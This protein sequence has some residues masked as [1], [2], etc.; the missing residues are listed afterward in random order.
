[1]N[2]ELMPEEKII[3]DA[4]RQYDCLKTEQ[5]IELIPYKSR[6]LVSRIIMGL[7]KRQL[8]I[9]D[10]SGNVRHDPRCDYDYKIEIAFWI[11]LKYIATGDV[12][13]NEHY[14][15]QYPSQIF[16]LK[17]GKQY[18]IFVLK[19]NE[20]H[21]LNVLVKTEQ[22]C[23]PD[24]PDEET[25]EFDDETRF[26]I[27]IPSDTMIPECNR[28]LGNLKHIFAVYDINTPPGQEPHVKFFK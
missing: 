1:M 3:I 17:G 2:N 6:E 8:L 4:L 14:R 21:L 24:T 10:A 27:A 26:I 12:K 13:Y 25:D 9:T 19:P 5:L 16:F 7:H 22:N 15:A 23:M 28:R 11:L 18:E 20:E